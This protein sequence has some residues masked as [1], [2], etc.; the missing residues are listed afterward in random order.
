M[1]PVFQRKVLRRVNVI[2]LWEGALDQ[3]VP[4]EALPEDLPRELGGL[5]QLLD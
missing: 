1:R 2:D 5:G 4:D 3:L